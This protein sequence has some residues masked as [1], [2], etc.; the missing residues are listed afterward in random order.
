MRSFVFAIS[1]GVC[2]V[3]PAPSAAQQIF[4]ERDGAVNSA[5]IIAF[6]Y[7]GA[8]Q[9]IVEACNANVEPGAQKFINLT[10]LVRSSRGDDA[11]KIAGFFGVGMGM[12]QNNGCQ[13]DHLRSYEGIADMYI[14]ALETELRR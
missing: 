2:S 1:V 5:L 10:N 14:E 11:I 12:T 6:T 13:V 7:L 3:S 9:G 8:A 4:F